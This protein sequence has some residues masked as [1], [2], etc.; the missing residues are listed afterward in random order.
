MHRDESEGERLVWAF[1]LGMLLTL[2][3]ACVAAYLGEPTPQEMYDF[4]ERL[5][6]GYP[7][8]RGDRH[9]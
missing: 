6:S 5:C 8:E 3:L 9:E 4:R 2:G 7:S 1:L